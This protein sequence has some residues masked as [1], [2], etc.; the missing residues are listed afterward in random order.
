MNKAMLAL[1][2][3]ALALTAGCQE[4][5]GPP[6]RVDVPQRPGEGVRH[7]RD[8][9]KP[10]PGQGPRSEANVPAPF[11][12]VPLVT[13][14][15]P[16]QKAYLRAYNDVG[17]PRLVI[18]VNR[19]VIP[20]VD[21]SRQPAPADGGNGSSKGNGV[22][23][24]S[25]AHAVPLRSID[26]EAVE[27]ILTDWLAAD[28]QVDIISPLVQGRTLTEAQRIRLREGPGDAI[29]RD[30]GG[31]VLVQVEGR[32]TEQAGQ[33]LQLRM[34]ARALNVGDG[35]SLAR[36]VVDVPA[37]LDK[38]KINRYTRFMARKLMDGMILSWQRMAKDGPPP[39]AT[40]HPGPAP[41]SPTTPPG[42]PI[43]APGGPPLRTPDSPSPAAAPEQPAPVQPNPAQPAPPQQSPAVQPPAP[44]ADAPP[45]KTEPA[46]PAES[47]PPAPEKG[48][49]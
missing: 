17:R 5:H 33:D 11:D 7:E 36:A 21:S 47:V 13:Q 34:V 20:E 35:R 42:A 30:L 2:V 44:A 38:P 3:A 12:D 27:S 43:P 1:V 37:P 24:N 9:I 40:N 48:A 19:G 39:A 45:A 22:A 26:T 49:Q 8:E 6:P 28:G 23:D 10:L 18:A 31:D 29:A 41:A 32:I 4:S 16:E 46:P 15:P 25:G 14:S